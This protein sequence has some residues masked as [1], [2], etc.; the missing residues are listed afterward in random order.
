MNDFSSATKLRS[1]RGRPPFFA[2]RSAELAALRKRFDDLCETGDATE[3]LALIVGVPGIGKTQ[4]GRRFVEEVARR[5]GP[6]RV[7][8]LATDVSMLEDDVAL[9]M[10][11]ARALGSEEVCRDV[12]EMDTRRTGLGVGAGVF[13]A[14]VTR[15]HVRHTSKLFGLLQR[16]GDVG[17]W[18]GK[19]LVLTI[20]E[21]QAVR[22][23]GMTALRVLHQG[24]HGCPLL[25]V[26]MGLQHT[27][28]VL[29]NPQ[30]GG[31]ISRV[32]EKITLGVLT[33]N[34]T[35]D[36]V[37]QGLMALG[38]TAP[39]AAVK[40]LA[41]ASLG[42]P[43]HVHGYLAGAQGAI[44]KHGDL[45][46]AP[47][48]EDALAAG[49]RARVG[50]YEDRLLALRKQSAVFP[51]VEALNATSRRSM[52]EDEAAQV[53]DAAGGDGDAVVETAIAHG[54]L[55]LDAQGDVGFGIPSF[56]AYMEDRLK[57][58]RRAHG[59]PPYT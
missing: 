26:A 23:E 33:E 12:A 7:A 47:A 36:A 59:R 49:D 16:S 58:G 52:P 13:K 5:Q 44:A 30:G 15:D 54:V 27:P 41:A 22:Q 42:F 43:Q 17:A 3:G 6:L 10:S 37:E 34:E 32:A 56:H 9:F 21:I 20:D 18:R 25:L 57:R 19:A 28:R 39:E 4:L 14:N 11:I 53:V 24:D 29:A 2:G 55:T 48:L 1:E 8:H 46:G 45:R 40:A 38:H 50:Y 51:I 35:T 31:G